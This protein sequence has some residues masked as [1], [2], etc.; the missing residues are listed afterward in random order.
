[1]VHRVPETRQV[2]LK[3][4]DVESAAGSLRPPGPTAFNEP[5]GDDLFF[6]GMPLAHFLVKQ[7][8]GWVVRMS[9]WL[10]EFDWNPLTST[11]S[12]HAGQPPLHPRLMLGL[13][14]YGTMQGVSSLRGIEE[15]ARLNLAAMYLGGGLTPDHST[16]GRFLAR[17]S[18]A[19][20]V[21]FFCD[22]TKQLLA[23]LGKQKAGPAAM[24]GTV[25]EAAAS[26]FSILKA[27]AI[28]KAAEEARLAAAKAP[29]NEE[30]EQA[31]AAAEAVAEVATRRQET[32]RLQRA[33]GDPSLATSEP[34]AVV[35]PRKD[36]A[37]RPGFKPSIMATEDR[38][39]VG[40]DVHP[41]NEAKSVVPMLEQ[42]EA[43]VGAEPTALL[44]DAGYNVASLLETF[45]DKDINALIPT[46]R[47]SNDLKEQRETTFTKADFKYLPENDA[48][49]CPNNKL[50]VLRAVCDGKKTYRAY[51]TNECSGCPLRARCTTSKDGTSRSIYRTPHDELR[52]GM[53]EVLSNPRARADYRQRKAMVEPVFSVLKDSQGLLRF[54][55]KGL[56]AVRMEFALHCMAY[57]VRTALRIAERAVVRAG[58]RTLAWFAAW[59]A[60]VAVVAMCV[61]HRLVRQ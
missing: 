19:L 17:H 27:E 26:R 20:T 14:L 45:V 11:Y 32:R 37:I 3:F 13:V 31:A 35:Q 12:S 50:L 54:R 10:H 49:R 48:Y 36:G 28:K 42:Y 59:R 5:S 6:G 39:I 52:E 1:M 61:P 4:D 44:G 46:G 24:D 55:R 8:Q 23:A 53:A 43:I 18:A 7:K 21:E 38:M 30:L 16:I 57:N 47:E 34:E 29:D 15:L 51:E 56:A 2:S 60:V 41:S 9:R 25:I 33:K 40:A 22:V 58:R